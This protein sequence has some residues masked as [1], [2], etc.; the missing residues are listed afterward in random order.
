[1]ACDYC[2]KPMPEPL[3]EITGDELFSVVWV[4][5][6]GSLY[7]VSQRA[8]GRTVY[9]ARAEKLPIRYCPVCGDDLTGRWDA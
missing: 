2:R 7:V 6:M 5:F 1:M 9:E 8:A 3:L 4:D